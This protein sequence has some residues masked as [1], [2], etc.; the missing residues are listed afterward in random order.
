MHKKVL[1]LLSI[2]LFGSSMSLG[3]Q[4][5]KIKLLLNEERYHFKTGEEVILGGEYLNIS[6]KELYFFV[7]PYVPDV[8]IWD[9]VIISYHQNKSRKYFHLSRYGS[10]AS[11]RIEKEDFKLLKTGEG[12]QASLNLT[13]VI[14][15]E[16]DKLEQIKP[17]MRKGT[18]HVIIGYSNMIKG[19]FNL[20]N[21]FLG[22]IESD[23][24]KIIIQNN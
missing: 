1:F 24:I 4:K 12:I 10:D 3:A 23:T 8:G 2:F 16:S 20:K 6:S 19:N 5:E 7:K 14:S 17:F 13:Y 21:I 9:Y 15:E 22:N 11:R 18:Y